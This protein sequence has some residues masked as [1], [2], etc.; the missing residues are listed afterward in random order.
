MKMANA[1]CSSNCIEKLEKLFEK[2]LWRAGI[3]KD[4]KLSWVMIHFEYSASM[5]ISIQTL[6]AF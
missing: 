1:K 5:Q 6:A 2:A 3:A 4:E